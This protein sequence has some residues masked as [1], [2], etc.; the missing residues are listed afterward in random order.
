MIVS[1]AVV[2]NPVHVPTLP[3]VSLLFAFHPTFTLA[4]FESGRGV[5]K[6]FYATESQLLARNLMKLLS[7]RKI[8]L[9]SCRPIRSL[10][11]PTCCF[12]ISQEFSQIPICIQE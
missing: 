7:F 3:L 2:T 1:E 9:S 12:A 11:F 5:H 8:S 6:E 10:I 4:M